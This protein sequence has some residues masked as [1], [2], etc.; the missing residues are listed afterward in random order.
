MSTQIFGS[1][2]GPTFT[3]WL[4]IVVVGVHMVER[5][6]RQSQVQRCDVADESATIR[7]RK[8]LVIDLINSLDNKF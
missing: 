1:V 6:I 3:S 4:A 5:P 7:G 8:L 2:K